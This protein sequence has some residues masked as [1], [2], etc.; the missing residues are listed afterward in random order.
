MIEN[1]FILI[2][3]IGEKTEKYLWGKG[4]LTWNDLEKI[5]IPTLSGN[6]KKTIQNHLKLA[7][8]ALD[9]MD[10]SFFARYLPKKEYWR[11]YREFRPRTLFLD[12]ETTGLSP[13]Y[14]VI[15]LIGTF[16]SHRNKIKIFLRGN[17]LEEIKD[18][19]QDYEIVV[20]FNGKKF[21]IPFIQKEF[22]D[23]KLPPVHIDL[24]FLLKS[25]G[26]TGSLKDIEKSAGIRREKEIQEINGKKA[27]A[28]W[29]RFV[30]GDNR[31][32][33]KLILYNIYDTINLEKL[34]KFIYIRKTERIFP[35][36]KSDLIRQ[37]TPTIAIPY[38]K[39]SKTYFNTEGFEIYRSKIKTSMEIKVNMLTKKIYK[40]LSVGIDLSSSEE[41]ASGICILQE[42]KVYTKRLKT[43]E[44]IISTVLS[45]DPSIISIDSPLSLPRGRCCTSDRCECRKYGITRECERILKKR[46]IN[47]YP[48][49][50]KSMQKLTERGIRMSK[51]FKAHGYQ[52]IE[53]YPGA[54]QDILG[55]PRKRVNLE[56]LKKNLINMGINISSD[57]RTL[58][59]DEIDAITS[60]LTG[61]FYLAGMYEA[62]GNSEEGYLI[63]PNLKNK[64]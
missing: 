5:Y 17:N 55:F 20:T 38:N 62:I 40:P 43:D 58:T 46:G 22:P 45:I 27:P 44:E 10:S 19:L 42:D 28:L 3:G 50:I 15:T 35:E 18:Y 48:C 31:A 59:H 61:Y 37:K 56:E 11:L 41:R 21:D 63:I 4:I 14:S 26:F 9:R 53:S 51:I 39:L 30:N 6:K 33:E 2:P 23:I 52:V 54:T 60:A 8:V 64:E 49:L 24:K 1:S 36:V 25:L 7:R 32:L 29:N 47:I 12:I 57:K 16:D 34:M 13:Y